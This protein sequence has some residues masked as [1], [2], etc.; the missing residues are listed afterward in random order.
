[1]S[2]FLFITYSMNILT[3][4]PYTTLALYCKQY[5]TPKQGFYD[6]ADFTNLKVDT[7]I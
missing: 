7:V 3:T 1:M 4:I 2:L 6:L 5:S